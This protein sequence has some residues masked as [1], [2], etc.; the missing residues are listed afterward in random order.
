MNFSASPGRRRHA[1]DAVGQESAVGSLNGTAT[2]SIARA[3]P[4]V[5]DIA[6]FVRVAD[7]DLTEYD[8]EV[9]GNQDWL[10]RLAAA[11]AT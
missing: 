2:T 7:R 6:G 10:A 5:S 9:S 4:A 3:G 11:V 8:I 1:D